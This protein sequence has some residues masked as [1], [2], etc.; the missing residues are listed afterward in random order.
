VITDVEAAVNMLGYSGTNSTG[1]TIVN[2]NFHDNRSGIDPNSL[3]SEKLSP[4]SGTTMVGNVVADNDN[5]EAPNNE[6]FAVAFGNGIVLGGTS[7]NL[8]ERNLVTGHLLGGVVVTDLPDDFT[9]ENNVVRDN[10]FADNQYD[11]VYLTATG[12]STLAGNCFEGNTITTEFPEGLQDKAVC[13]GPEVDLG[14]LSGILASVP[15]PPPDVDW[16]TVPAPPDQENMA[17]AETAPPRPATDVPM[18]VDLDAITL[19][20]G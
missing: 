10:D 5:V 13:G 20:K 7:N 14:D 12:A 6:G 1:V 15:P 19:P 8:V 11:L 17:D 16:K 3:N 2:S 9:P 18:K 4:N